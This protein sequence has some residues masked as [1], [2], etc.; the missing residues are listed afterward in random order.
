VEHQDQARV[1][2]RR[3]EPVEIEEVAVARVQT[4]SSK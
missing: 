1:G 4:L 2:I 3:L